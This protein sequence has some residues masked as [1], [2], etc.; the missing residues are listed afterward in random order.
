MRKFVDADSAS[1]SRASTGDDAPQQ[2][3][4]FPAVTVPAV[5]KLGHRRR[6]NVEPEARRGGMVGGHTRV[7]KCIDDGEVEAWWEYRTQHIART[8]ATGIY[9]EKATREA[10]GEEG[11]P[12]E[13][14]GRQG[15][16]SAGGAHVQHVCRTFV[17][18]GWCFSTLRPR[19][20][21]FTSVCESSINQSTEL[22][23]LPPANCD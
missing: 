17:L 11:R 13:T 14:Q 19:A 21:F 1:L 6:G 15:D 16:F 10:G 2:S 22:P 8:N 18:S 9:S 12:R 23:A 3:E 7:S 5:A 4:S 20:R